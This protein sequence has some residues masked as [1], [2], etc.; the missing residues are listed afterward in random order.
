MLSLLLVPFLVQGL[1]PATLGTVAFVAV[2]AWVLYGAVNF[3]L[4][5]RSGQK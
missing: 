5:Q 1:L 3:T 4:T 2:T